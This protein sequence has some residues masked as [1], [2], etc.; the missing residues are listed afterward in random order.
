M[1]SPYDQPQQP[2]DPDAEYLTVQETAWVL[3]CSVKHL[4]R[5]VRDGLYTASR[6]GR[7]LVFDREARA[8]IY[9]VR[10][11]DA[12]PLRRTPRRARKPAARPVSN[13]A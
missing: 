9:D 12:K 11:I 13:A 2:A 5:G 7:R 6:T 8:H 1:T 3:R 4:R 10:R